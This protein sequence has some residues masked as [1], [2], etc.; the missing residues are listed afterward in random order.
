MQYVDV[1]CL[2]ADID[3]F[4]ISASVAERGQNAGRETWANALVETNAHPLEIEDRDAAR[5]FFKGFGAWDDAEIAA[6]SNNE[7]DALVLQFAAGDLREIQDL[8]P[9]EGLGDI[10]WQEAEKLA[11][12]GTIGGRLWADGDKLTIYIG[13]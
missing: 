7:L 3:P 11:A 6:W 13:D 1:T 2:V 8:C 4:D 5:A 12:A 9:G 10:D